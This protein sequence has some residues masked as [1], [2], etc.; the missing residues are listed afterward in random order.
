MALRVPVPPWFLSR[1]RTSWVAVGA[2]LLFVLAACS[3]TSDSDSSDSDSSGVGASDTGGRGA[4]GSVGGTSQDCDPGSRVGDPAGA[5]S[6]AT[7]L[8]TTIIVRTPAGYDPLVASPLLVVYSGATF[9]AAMTESDTGLTGPATDGGYVIAYVDHLVPDTDAN[10]QEAADAV[11]SVQGAWCVDPERVYLSGHSDGGSM[12]HLVALRGLVNAA[13]I[14]PS[15]SG[16]RAD[17][18]PQV[19]CV[20]QPLPL[21]ELHSKD[22]EMFPV[23]DG[24][25]GEVAKWFAACSGCG[26]PSA[27]DASGCIVYSSCIAGGDVE[28]CEGTGVHGSWPPERNQQILDFFARF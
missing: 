14:A 19:S 3:D 6:F 11:T 1:L 22:D 27:A 18:L 7:P 8:G 15:A 13:A 5:T 2:S 10:I 21:L 23:A 16:L 26:A 12:T 25:G 17:S 9:D 28:Y 4:G 24:F 20:A